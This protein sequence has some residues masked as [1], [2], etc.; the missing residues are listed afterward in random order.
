MKHCEHG[1][2]HVTA[3]KLFPWNIRSLLCKRGGVKLKTLINGISTI[4][5]NIVWEVKEAT[6]Q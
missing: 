3:R 4:D 5:M 2:F 1:L 6:L